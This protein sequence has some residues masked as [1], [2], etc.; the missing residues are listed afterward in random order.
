MYG[1]KTLLI[2]IIYYISCGEINEYLL[3]KT[4]LTYLDSIMYIIYVYNNHNY[5]LKI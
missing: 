3:N 1:I 2:T 5:N 4:F